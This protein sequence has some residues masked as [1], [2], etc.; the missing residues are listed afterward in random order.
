MKTWSF[1]ELR[2]LC[3][4]RGIPNDS[5]STFSTFATSLDWRYYRAKF[6]AEQAHN[7]LK[8]LFAQSFAFGDEK[9]NEAEF[10]YEAYVEACVQSLH[11]MGD[12]LSQIINILILGNHFSED[13]VSIKRVARYMATKGLAPDVLIEINKLLNSNEFSFIEAFCNTIKHRRLIETKYRSEYGGDYRNEE[14]L[15]FVEFNYKGV[16]YPKTW[17]KDIIDKYREEV[18]KLVVEVGLKINDFSK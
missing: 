12:I 15:V 3:R 18:F 16:T 13:D 14:G 7:I 2:D 9:Y 5:I 8:D 4:K 17:A 1:E 11:S 10:S 6:H